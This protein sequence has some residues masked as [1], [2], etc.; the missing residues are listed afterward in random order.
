MAAS[1]E[2]GFVFG[3]MGTDCTALKIIPEMHVKKGQHDWGSSL[4]GADLMFLG[5]RVAL[6]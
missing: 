2:I 1:A 3:A 6:L 4:K 5:W